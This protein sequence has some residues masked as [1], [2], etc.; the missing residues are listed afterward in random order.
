M[1]RMDYTPNSNRFKGAKAS[2]PAPE[3]NERQKLNKVVVGT[4]KKKKVGFGAKLLNVFV[5][6]DP[7]TVRDSLLTDVLV[8][9]VKKLITDTVSNGLDMLFYSRTGASKY[10]TPATR[11]SYSSISS[12]NYGYQSQNTQVY[13]SQNYNNI[14]LPTRGDAD[15]VLQAMD[16][17]LGRYRIVSIADLYDLVGWQSQYTDSNYGWT[18]LHSASAIHVR[19]GWL[20]KL[21]KAM[22][23][24]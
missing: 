8:P 21:P 5:Q 4:A 17:L 2:A 3:Q 13:Q 24:N 7:E 12:P 11:Y 14:V 18:D 20:L 15:S 9:A 23:I 10:Q 1:E 16:E 6:E 19:D 22:Q